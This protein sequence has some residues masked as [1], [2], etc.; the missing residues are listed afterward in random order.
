MLQPMMI[1][2]LLI[3]GMCLALL[4][5]IKV[6]LARRLQLDEARVGGL[7]S[8][9][10]FTLIP[11][12]LTVG[13]LTDQ[14]GP[15]NVL[16]GGSLLLVASL[17]LLASAKGYP[18]ALAAVILLCAGWTLLVVVGN[19]LTPKAFPSDNIAYATNL[20]NVFFGIG[21][22]LTPL[23]VVSLLR[24][25][26]LPVVVGLLGALSMVPGLFAVGVD[27]SGLTPARDPTAPTGPGTAELL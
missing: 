20:A 19:V 10:G 6:P 12:M 23:F 15:Q 16:I 14:F 2:L 22:F 25:S 21:A 4:G 11:I 26:S 1:A 13:F 8:I 5:S 7:I 17:A 9:F 18:T 27:F 3:T 24:R